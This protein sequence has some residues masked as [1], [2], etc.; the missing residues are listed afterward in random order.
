MDDYAGCVDY[1]SKARSQRGVGSLDGGHGDRIRRNV[2]A[3]VAQRRP[4]VGEL[5][6]HRF[7]HRDRAQLGSHAAQGLQGKHPIDGRQTPV[8]ITH[9]PILIQRLL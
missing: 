4:T 9:A 7:R 1:G 5:G 3:T 2:C 6:A 8:L